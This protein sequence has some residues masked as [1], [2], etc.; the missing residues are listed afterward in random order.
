MVDMLTEKIENCSI[1]RLEGEIDASSAL[2]LD[3]TIEQIVQEETTHLVIEC[4]NL[5]YISS[6]GLGVIIASL[7]DMQQE[8]RKVV[9]ANV[10]PTVMDIFTVLGLENHLHIAPDLH[11]A[12]LH[13]R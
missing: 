3:K 6:A 2:Q 8:K 11:A 7:K 13:C 12:L 1:V 5:T 4:T 10:D 9:L